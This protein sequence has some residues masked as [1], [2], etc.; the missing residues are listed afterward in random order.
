M[1]LVTLVSVALASLLSSDAHAAGAVIPTAF[2]GEWNANPA[3]CGTREDES[4]LKIEPHHVYFW[5]SSGPVRAA[6]AR[7]REL[8]LILELSGEGE[9]WLST[10]EFVLSAH[11]SMLVATGGAENLKRYR[12][13]SRKR[14][15]NSS[16][17][18]P[19]RGAA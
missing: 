2:V 19:L 16:K 11:G 18:T 10:H 4:F 5:E 7:G 13:A 17:P 14:P 3:K 15:N 12:C 6:V 8:A 1:R 9:T